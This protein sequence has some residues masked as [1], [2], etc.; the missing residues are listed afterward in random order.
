MIVVKVGGSL[1]DHPRLASGLRAYLHSL[2]PQEVL[3]VPGGGPFAEA[4]GVPRPRSHSRQG[5]FTLA[6]DPGDGPGR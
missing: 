1:F 5:G 2:A 3:L 4:V 6:R